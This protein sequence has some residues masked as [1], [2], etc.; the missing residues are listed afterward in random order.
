MNYQELLAHFVRDT[1][2]M[3]AASARDDWDEVEHLFLSRQHYENELFEMLA[4]QT[5]S[6]DDKQ[7]LL[8]AQAMTQFVMERMRVVRDEI[9]GQLQEA[10]VSDRLEKAYAPQ[11]D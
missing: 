9:A 4:T 8:E 5:L 6:D 2:A 1:H 7:K 11:G 3:M 10:R